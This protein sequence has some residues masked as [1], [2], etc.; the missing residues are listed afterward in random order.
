MIK[1]C[2]LSP[3]SSFES[4]WLAEVFVP[5]AGKIEECPMSYFFVIATL[6]DLVLFPLGFRIWTVFF[7]GL[8]ATTPL[9]SLDYRKLAGPAYLC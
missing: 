2:L 5:F 7:G 8:V 1:E 9:V 6:L 3:D 4:I